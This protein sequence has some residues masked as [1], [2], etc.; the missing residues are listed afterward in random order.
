MMEELNEQ[1]I[2]VEVLGEQV[3]HELGDNEDASGADKD[4]DDEIY[5]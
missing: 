4:S 3:V 2:N 1:E 5:M